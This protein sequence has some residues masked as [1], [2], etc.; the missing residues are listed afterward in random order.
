MGTVRMVDPTALH[1]ADPLRL[2][3]NGRVTTGHVMSWAW[4]LD[5]RV[6]EGCVVP[7]PGV[8]GMS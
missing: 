4:S 1:A 2:G 3:R 6:D 7:A 5:R 8:V